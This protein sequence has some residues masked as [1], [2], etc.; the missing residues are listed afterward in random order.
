MYGIR[1]CQHIVYHYPIVLN[2]LVN[3][4]HPEGIP[5]PETNQPLNSINN[6]CFI[7]LSY[8]QYFIVRYL[9]SSIISRNFIL[10]SIIVSSCTGWWWI[11]CLC[12]FRC[13]VS[14]VVW[15]WVITLIPICSIFG[16]RN[17]KKKKL[18]LY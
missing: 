17:R 1:F 14:I 7:Y 9:W 12:I 18:C 15:G 11:I 6:L 4:Q 2:S 8:Y 16:K 13:R 5:Y 10:I 3:I